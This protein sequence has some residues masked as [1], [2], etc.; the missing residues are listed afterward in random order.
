M[1][2]CPPLADQ[3]TG[4]DRFRQIFR[5]HREHGCDLRLER[6]GPADQRAY[7]RAIVERLKICRDPEAGYARYLCPGCQ[8]AHRV[9][10][11]CKT[12]FCPSCGKVKVDAWVTTLT[13]D[14]LDVPHLHLT[15]TI[16]DEL[17]PVFHQDRSLL[18]VLLQAATQVVRDVLAET[19]PGVQVGLIYV[20]HT[21]GRDL[22]FKPHVH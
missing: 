8:Y 6:E 16:D 1:L 15:L 11:S 3:P 2:P 17:R 20:I 14:L 13:R 9:P 7:V 12:R 10:F 21:F 19:H 22:G 4:Q 5:D 18:D